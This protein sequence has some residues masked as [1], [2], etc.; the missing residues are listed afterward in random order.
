M[1]FLL[2]TNSITIDIYTP[3][4]TNQYSTKQAYTITG[5]R[6]QSGHWASAQFLHDVPWWHIC[7]IFM[8]LTSALHALKYGVS[9]L[10]MH[11]FIMYVCL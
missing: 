9:L 4:I 11:I 6:G 3:V 10:Q 1:K 2:S 8:T 7:L 5:C